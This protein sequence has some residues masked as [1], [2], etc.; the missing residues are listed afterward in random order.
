MIL[1]LKRQFY[2][3]GTLDYKM[4]EIVLFHRKKSDLPRNQLADLAGVGKTVI[5]DIEKGKE[6][7]RFS[8]LQKVLQTLNI[9]ITFTSP[10]ME[11][12]NEKS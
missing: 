6:T 2:E 12:L 11:V 10:L 9:K 1:P 7:I 3:V 5:Y 4:S 8:T